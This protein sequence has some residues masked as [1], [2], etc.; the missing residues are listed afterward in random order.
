MNP[1]PMTP[2]SREIIGTKDM[3]I[4]SGDSC[5]DESHALWL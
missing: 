1:L 3:E 2:F 4:T 5:N